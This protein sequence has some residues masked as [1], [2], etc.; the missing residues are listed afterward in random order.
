MEIRTFLIEFSE[1]AFDLISTRFRVQ[2]FPSFSLNSDRI[3]LLNTSKVQI[4]LDIHSFH[5]EVN[6][7]SS[8]KKIKQFKPIFINYYLPR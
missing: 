6:L 1:I 2:L 8:V 5:I 7:V 4:L 3:L